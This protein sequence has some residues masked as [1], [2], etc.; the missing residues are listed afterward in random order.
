MRAIGLMKKLAVVLA[1]V[2]VLG[3]TAVGVRR[4][5]QPNWR[6]W[7]GADV[8][9][10]LVKVHEPGE[11]L[12]QARAEIPP[13]HFIP[14][15]KRW[16]ELPLSRA[17]LAKP[18]RAWRVVM[19]GDSIVNDTWG[20]R[21]GDELQTRL[22][23]TRLD[24]TAVI[25]EAKGCWWYAQSDRVKRFVVPR[26]PD[27]L[28]I[29]GISN[30]GDSEAVRQVIRQTRAAK[31][32]DVLLLTGPVGYVDPADDAQWSKERADSADAW[33]V[34][35]AALAREEHAG[36]FDLQLAWGDYIRESGKPASWFK[37]D[38]VHANARGQAMLGQFMTEF[39]S[40]ADAK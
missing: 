19:L 23:H 11:H 40:P 16:E 37:R 8:V 18:S 34:R 28:I 15:A 4:W 35:L 5:L 32:C 20:S 21:F 22:P 3:L 36:F 17:L 7:D 31:A 29:G 38:D 9:Y 2:V 1:V 13:V 39:L 27:L 12:A 24:L 33:H 26:E 30:R 25:G 6:E 10:F 14:P